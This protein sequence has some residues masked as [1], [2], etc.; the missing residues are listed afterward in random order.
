VLELQRRNSHYEEFSGTLRGL[1]VGLV[2]CGW[3][4]NLALAF[5]CPRVPVESAVL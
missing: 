5:A 4:N 1:Q 2:V 3:D